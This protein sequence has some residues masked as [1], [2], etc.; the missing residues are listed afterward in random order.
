MIDGSGGEEEDDYSS[1]VSSEFTGGSDFD[2]E[3]GINLYLVCVW[4]GEGKNG[5][6]V[7][8]CYLSIS[9]M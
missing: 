8:M 1:E 5:W 3:E 7:E 4:S 6:V 2:E 9:K